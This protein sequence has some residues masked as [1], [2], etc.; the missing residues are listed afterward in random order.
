MVNT[1]LELKRQDLCTATIEIER[2]KQLDKE[3]KDN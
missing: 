3:D 1:Q 2:L